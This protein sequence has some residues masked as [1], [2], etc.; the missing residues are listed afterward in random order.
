MIVDRYCIILLL[1][2]FSSCISHENMYSY[3]LYD[4]K[5]HADFDYQR[6]EHIDSVPGYKDS[7]FAVFEGIHGNYKIV[8]FMSHDYGECY[9]SYYDSTNNFIAFK[10][11]EK[12]QV[13][14]G[15]LSSTHIHADYPLSYT[16]LRVN[17]KNIKIR[18]VN[19][20]KK[21]NIQFPYSDSIYYKSLLVKR[22]KGYVYLR[23]YKR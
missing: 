17:A 14:D 19:S 2:C 12:N 18:K 6:I 7:I 10:I 5:E 22:K 20:I 9:P 16:L 1:L 3:Y 11:N 21:F 23:K 13:V 4:Q 15:F 8:R